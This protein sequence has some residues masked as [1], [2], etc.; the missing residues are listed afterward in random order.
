MDY[1]NAKIFLYFY[2]LVKLYTVQNWL[3]LGPHL[4]TY[5]TY[6]IF[7]CLSR[8]FQ[9]TYSCTG[10]SLTCILTM[11]TDYFNLQGHVM[12]FRS[13][14]LRLMIIVYNSQLEDT[15]KEF[16]LFTLPRVLTRNIFIQNKKIV[17]LRTNEPSIGCTIKGIY[18]FLTLLH[19]S[20]K[21]WAYKIA[22]TIHIVHTIFS[23][24]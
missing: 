3:E 4:P 23:H 16:T 6:D 19:K 2:N 15:L 17:V 20:I 9:S 11:W 13:V 24:D 5:C 8:C 18:F 1:R 10:C 22:G 21:Y 7:S 14:E 12:D